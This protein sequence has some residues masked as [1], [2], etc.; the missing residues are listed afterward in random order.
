MAE[1][2][3]VVDVCWTDRAGGARV[4]LARSVERGALYIRGEDGRWHA[5]AWSSI[6]SDTEGAKDAPTTAW[7]S[8]HADPLSGPGAAA[9]QLHLSPGRWQASTSR[10]FLGGRSRGALRGSGLK[11]VLIFT[12]DCDWDLE[13]YYRRHVAWRRQ[14]LGMWEAEEARRESGLVDGLESVVGFGRTGSSYY[15]RFEGP[16]VVPRLGSALLAPRREVGKRDGGACPHFWR[17]HSASMPATSSNSSQ[18]QT[19][20][21]SVAVR[22]GVHGTLGRALGDDA[23]GRG[24]LLDPEA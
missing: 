11:P 9:G 8:G 17:T 24:A 23:R 14:W 20:R 5:Y 12:P 3:G 16:G 19:S 13:L 18:G 22:R 10:S 7:R 6:V 1:R 21:V 15:A 4:L 2:F